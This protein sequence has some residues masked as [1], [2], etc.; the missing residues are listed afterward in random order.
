MAQVVYVGRRT[1]NGGKLGHGFAPLSKPDAPSYFLL[2]KATYVIG[3]IYDG[4]AQVD[5][6]GRLKTLTSGTLSWTRQ[7]VD[8]DIRAAWELADRQAYREDATR[9]AVA[10][11]RRSTAYA[12]ALAPM[13]AIMR[14]ARTHAEA[15]EIANAIRAELLEGWHR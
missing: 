10:R 6:Q 15:S 4:E 8:D 13:L 1:C 14:T 5:D 9:L 12:E 7:K 11:A 3:G 2:K